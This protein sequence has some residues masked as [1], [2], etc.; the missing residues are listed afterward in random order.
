MGEQ[1]WE[2]HVPFSYG[3]SLWDLVYAQGA[4]PVGVET[5]AN[6][7]RMEKSLRLQNADL[8]TEYNLYEAGLARPKV[9]EANFYGK[10]PYLEQR[11]LEHQAAYLCTLSMTNNVDSEGIARYPVGSCP[12][13]IP[14]T[15]EVPIDS[16]GRRSYLTSI[17]YG[18]SIGKNIGLGYLPYEYCQEGREF[19]MEYLGEQFPMK[20]ESVGYKPLYDPE[21]KLPKS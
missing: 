17:A 7:R 19:T 9:K 20:V 6:S 12:L 11:E 21:N 13:M 3:L 15:G 8:L 16:K 14:E 4:T 1:G 5:Y 10:A 18:P 2:L